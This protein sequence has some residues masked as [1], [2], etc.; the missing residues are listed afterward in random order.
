MPPRYQAAAH[1]F[2]AWITPSAT[3]S[4]D[5]APDRGHPLPEAGLLSSRPLYERLIRDGIAADIREEPVDR[6]TARRLATWLAGRPQSP[7]FARAIVR[8]AETGAVTQALKAQLHIRVRS[9]TCPG[10]PQVHRLIQYCT[11]RG[12]EPGPAGENSAACDQIDRADA[13][14]DGLRQQGRAGRAHPGQAWPGID[15]SR[16]TVLAHQERETQTI[17]LVLDATTASIAIATHADGREA[18][19][20]E[21]E[22]ISRSLPKAPTTDGS[23][24]RDQQDC[25]QQRGTGRTAS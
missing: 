10:R 6:L 12:A 21:I 4:A 24:S 14:L 15:G 9:G 1:R 2:P 23:S 22:Q 18:R 13:M 7:D 3:S 8:F 5:P 25:G 11:A 19:I 20:R 16:N 17:T